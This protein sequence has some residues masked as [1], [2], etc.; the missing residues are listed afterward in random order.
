MDNSYRI[1]ISTSSLNLEDWTDLYR[2][3][4]SIYTNDIAE[5]KVDSFYS[6][7]EKCIRVNY[8]LKSESGFDAY[9]LYGNEVTADVLKQF[10]T[11]TCFSIL[12]QKSDDTEEFTG[13]SPFVLFLRKFRY[14]TKDKSDRSLVSLG[15]DTDGMK[16]QAKANRFRF[17]CSNFF[18]FFQE[19]IPILGNKTLYFYSQK[20]Q[21]T[22]GLAGKDTISK[23]EEKSSKQFLPLLHI[24]EENYHTIFTTSSFITDE[25]SKDYLYVNDSLNTIKNDFKNTILK[26]QESKLDLIVNYKDSLF[27][28]WLINGYFYSYT[29]DALKNLTF[30]EIKRI[31]QTLQ[32]YKNIIFG[33]IQNIIFHGGKSGFFYCVFDNKNNISSYYQNKLP[34]FNNKE[35][36]ANQFMRVGIYDFFNIGIADSFKKREVIERNLKDH[37]DNTGDLYN[38]LSLIDFFDPNS[39]STIGISPLY[40][41]YAARLG[42]KSYVKTVFKYNGYFGVESNEVINSLNLKKR[43]ITAWDNKTPSFLQEHTV[44]FAPGTHYDLILPI[45]PNHSVP[46]PILQRNTMSSFTQILEGQLK[47]ASPIIAIDLDFERVASISNCKSKEHEVAAISD[48]GNNLIKNIGNDQDEIALNLN[49]KDFDYRLVFKL[50]AYLQLKAENG[51][52][53]IILINGTDDFIRKFCEL[54]TPLLNDVRDG[55]F[56]V[57]SNDAAIILISEKLHVQIICGETKGELY[58]LNQEFMKYYLNNFSE[59][60][61]LYF[62]LADCNSNSSIENI[63]KDF[64]LPYDIIIEYPNGTTPFETYALDYLKRRIISNNLGFL[65]NQENTHLDSFIR[66]YFFETDLMFQNSFFAFRYAFLIAKNICNLK[67]SGGK[68]LVLIGYQQKSEQLLKAIKRIVNDKSVHIAIANDETPNDKKE[69]SGIGMSFSFNIDNDGRELR[70]SILKNPN[71][72]QFATVIPIGATLSTSDKIITLFRLW[73]EQQYFPNRFPTNID[74]IYNHCV[75]IVRDT[76]GPKLTKLEVE[77]KW[78]TINLDQ[79]LIETGFQNAK[80]I[81]FTIQIAAN[82]SSSSN[83]KI[84]KNVYEEFEAHE[85]DCETSNSP[86]GK[87]E[88]RIKQ[89]NNMVTFPKAWQREMYVNLA[90]NASIYSQNL[91][92]FPKVEPCDES[93]HQEELERLFELRN[94]IYKGHFDAFNSHHKYF[95][96]TEFVR[97]KNKS[98]ID[99]LK[100][101]KNRLHNRNINQ[102]NKL[103]ILIVPNGETESELVDI[104]NDQIFDENALIVYLDV[105]KHRDNDHKMSFLKSMDITN[106]CFHYIDFVLLTGDNYHQTKSYLYSFI[107]DRTDPYLRK[108]REYNS[109]NDTPQ[110]HDCIFDSIITVV[111]NL[112]HTEIK[113]IKNDVNHFFSF[114]NLYYPTSKLDGRECELCKLQRYYDDLSKKTVLESCKRVIQKNIAKLT[115]LE[116]RKEKDDNVLEQLNDF[117][118]YSKSK[119]DFL[120]LVMTHELYYRI[121]IIAKGQADFDSLIQNDIINELDAFYDKLCERQRTGTKGTESNIN[122]CINNWFKIPVAEEYND[123]RE[124]ISKKLQTDKI[125]SFLKVISSPQLSQYIIIRE[126][127]HT[128]LLNVL[129]EIITK[130]NKDDYTYDDLKI[131]K[132]I[133]KSLSFLKSNALV[134]KDVIVGIWEVLD[135]VISNLEKTKNEIEIIEKNTKEKS[136]SIDTE[137]KRL[138]EK[139]RLTRSENERRIYLISIKIQENKDFEYLKGEKYEADRLLGYKDEIIRDF[140]RDIQFFIKN[141]IVE[142]DA[143]ASFLGELIRTGT[144][145]ASF[146]NIK[147]SKTQL[148]LKSNY[149]LNIKNDLFEYFKDKRIYHN[150]SFRKEYINFLVWLF[151]D[152]TTII[153]K[154]LDNFSKELEEDQDFHFSFYRQGINGFELKTINDFKNGISFIKKRILYH[155]FNNE[156]RYSSFRPYLENGD[157]IDYVEKLIFVTY[158]NLILK[159]LI[160]NKNQHSIDTDIKVLLEVFSQI[161]GA[162]AAFFILRKDRK[163]YPI[164]VFKKDS[165]DAKWDYEKWVL[166]NFYTDRILSSNSLIYPIIPVF[167]IKKHEKSA[168][169]YGEQNNIFD[170]HSLNVYIINHPED[171]ARVSIT[172]L[173]NKTNSLSKDETEFRIKTQEQGRLLLLLQNEIN[174]YLLEYLI[175]ERVFDLW[176]VSKKSS[177]KFEKV[178]S[179]SNHTFSA[180]YEEMNEFEHIGKDALSVLY[181]TWFFLTD[182]TI[183]FLYSDI[184]R[185]TSNGKHRLSISDKYVI[186][187]KN[188]LGK[189]FN[190][191]FIFILTC[192][193]DKRWNEENEP[194]NNIIVINGQDIHDYNGI[195]KKLE[196]EKLLDKSISVN[197]HLL[198]S[199]IAQ[200]LHNSLGYN[201]HGHRNWGEIKRIMISI[202]GSYIKIED[203]YISVISE[204][205]RKNLLREVKRFRDTKRHIQALNCDVYSSTT[206][207]TLQGVMN[208]MNQ[209]SY[210][211]K[212][213]Y[214]FNKNNNFF[215]TIKY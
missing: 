165:P 127:A 56:P 169:H 209:H 91:M 177:R 33:L 24:T 2:F 180:K 68:D 27:G 104:I 57:W 200:C 183:N 94:D 122:D 159:D 8:A 39:I 34:C 88:D 123:L 19:D 130:K 170:A 63:S 154:T 156:D 149:N 135:R 194:K 26:R 21:S 98:F 32:I 28:Q 142:D 95:F 81:H 202:T 121:S 120:R 82:T 35:S 13:F 181:R 126:Y 109:E 189:T 191:K 76:V 50:L 36:K 18:I 29:P 22:I 9:E 143:K 205:S 172:F 59:N 83:I 184:E 12:Y 203:T 70:K 190:E 90:E 77:Q 182:Q 213:E 37:S 132:S 119:R 196:Q 118:N 139:S 199:L 197:R 114:I 185:N 208:Y 54:I 41:R 131:V 204:R 66:R 167:D 53:K 38:G 125:I 74:F 207:T 150:D 105:I 60:D 1:I 62:N 14:T 78:N 178:Y 71:H 193:L 23:N 124:Y 188:T 42:I 173:Y 186:D 51:F 210:P 146:D 93:Q 92:G 137:L 46:T 157:G 171:K 160:V 195:E 175:N 86:F 116:I 4:D 206:L 25:N 45:V 152:N 106:A 110:S 101:I 100:I 72:F 48:I 155:I 16:N 162:D 87:S 164:S 129:Y 11:N 158:A 10:G 65:V 3:I 133:L 215:V 64:I 141:A 113:E 136:I 198:R 134:R 15:I 97:R 7:K 144:E 174:R 5:N 211:Y 115:C 61:N 112:P 75:I 40:V 166:D 153:R 67:R 163:P 107:Y 102:Q 201:N 85:P 168:Q 73:H 20:E 103:N 44:H 49:G 17:K 108:S 89:L 43:L 212:C 6:L 117:R 140:S 179:K 99:W 192:L 47:L 30:D 111:N 145:M 176:L 79:R 96:D 84:G 58:S 151:Y 214:G 161:M 187:K 147:I 148:S 31:I 52:R 69:A 128:K 55:E 138:N 80:E